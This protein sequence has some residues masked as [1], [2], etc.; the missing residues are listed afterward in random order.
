MGNRTIV[1]YFISI[2]GVSLLFFSVASAGSFAAD[3]WLFG[4]RFGDHTYAG[5]FDL[6]NQSSREAEI[7]LT[8]DLLGMQENL[9]AD[10]V[11]QDTKIPVPAA[12]IEFNPSATVSQA[13]TEAENPILASVNE[14]GLRTLI[15]QELP[16][17]T[18]SDGEISAVAEGLSE[19]L[20]T[21]IMPQSV[22]LTDF[23][24]SSQPTQTIASAEVA[25]DGFSVPMMD[26]IEALDGVSL[27]PKQP[28]SLLTFVE[29]SE[30]GLVEN[31]ELTRVA[32]VLYE[33]LLRT[34]FWV[35]DR[36][37]RTELLDGVTP[38]FEA[39]VNRQLGLDFKLTNPNDTSYMIRS[40]WSDGALH[41]SI[42]G[43]PLRYTYEPYVAET[44]TFKPKTTIQYNR[45]L[46]VG[47][48]VEL[49]KG[50]D[51]L[52]VV[53]Q[54]KVL[55]DGEVLN[56][57]P[58]S[59]DF[60]APVARVEEHALTRPEPNTGTGDGSAGSEGAGDNTGSTDNGSTG[61]ST[62]GNNPSGGTGSPNGTSPNNPQSGGS[63][64]DGS[65]NSN[66]G[67][68]PPS[69]SPDDSVGSVDGK[70]AAKPESDGHI[71]DKGGN[72]VK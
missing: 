18:L 27:E 15:Q 38:G 6:S 13:E 65:G 39:A 35:E 53:V 33:A 52:E 42:V 3:Q 21:G 32:S 68:K 1:T 54:R 25:A 51:G 46:A 5:P 61:G 10:L 50:K 9:Q 7:K 31:D 44:N 36:S 49:E 30:P 56:I 24:E 63:N 22:R 72:L 20:A 64:S 4:K 29:E 2:L 47:R 43:L 58:V 40:K 23:L 14:D 69:G 12:L 16:M 48:V 19:K 71:Y 8:S 67:S 60:Y 62:D 11:Y 41:I 34:N 70:P 17:L 28:F 26:V 59:E 55:E 66:A 45:D 37:I 57:E